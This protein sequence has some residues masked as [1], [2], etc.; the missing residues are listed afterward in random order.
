MILVTGATGNVGAAVCTELFADGEAFR[1]FVRDPARFPHADAAGVET[2]VGD[3]QD[4]SDIRN[5]LQGV[6]HAFLVTANS[7][8]Q[9]GIERRFCELAVEEGVQ[10]LVKVSSMEAGPDATAAF[11]RSHYE[12][13][14]F[15]KSS[16]MSWTMVQPNFFMQNLLIYAQAIRAADMFALP[17]GNAKTGIVDARD[18]GAVCAAAL[19]DASHANRTYQVTGR[20]LL[21]FHQVAEKMSAVLGRTIRY[22]EQSP[23]AFH[24]F[25]SGVVPSQWHVDAVCE[26]FAQI[27]DDALSTATTRLPPR[28][29]LSWS[30]S[31]P[32][33]LWALPSNNSRTMPVSSTALP[34]EMNLPWL[35]NWW[36]GLELLGFALLPPAKVLVS[37]LSFAGPLRT[38]YRDSTG[39]RGGTTTPKCFAHSLTGPSTR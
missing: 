20:E 9:A 6:S 14:Q 31:K 18:V 8:A 37:F 7:D 13:E 28:S 39:L 4:D 33:L 35:W 34:M 10:H 30:P 27:A 11:P 12:S 19:Q 5:A 23:E 3:M 22:V 32:T 15:I 16:G 26:L 17:L 2:L 21:T 24:E 29:M 38:M 25:L 36:N 1:A